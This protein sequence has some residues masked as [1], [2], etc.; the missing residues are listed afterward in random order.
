[1]H[2]EEGACVP[3][4]KKVWVYAVT[5]E[6]TRPEPRNALEGF[7]IDGIPQGQGRHAVVGSKRVQFRLGVVV[8]GE[9]LGG[10]W[11]NMW[12]VGGPEVDLHDCWGLRLAEQLPQHLLI[13][14]PA[15]ASKQALCTIF[16]GFSSVTLPSLPQNAVSLQDAGSTYS[17]LQMSESSCDTPFPPP[18]AQ[19][20]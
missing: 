13:S 18:H 7:V 12:A 9:A 1:M 4:A 10:P 6:V 14:P 20:A 8:E 3:M 11:G 19:G 2:F 16:L 17:L 15:G 5:H